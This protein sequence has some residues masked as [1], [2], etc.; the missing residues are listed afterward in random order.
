MEGCDGE[1]EWRGKV[2]RWNG[3]QKISDEIKRWNV[4]RR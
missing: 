1:M 2:E 4:K 3:F